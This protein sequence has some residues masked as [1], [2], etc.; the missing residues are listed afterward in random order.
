MGRMK[1]LSK[2][3][4]FA[5]K[6][7]TSEMEK[8]T[9]NFLHKRIF[10]TSS[11]ESVTFST[12]LLDNLNSRVPSLDSN[13]NLTKM[14]STESR[15]TIRIRGQESTEELVD[16]FARI[17]E[18]RE[19][20]DDS[21]TDLSR[22]GP[23]ASHSRMRTTFIE[24]SRD[25]ARPRL[26]QRRTTLKGLS[27]PGMDVTVERRKSKRVTLSGLS[28]TISQMSH[29]RNTSVYSRQSNIQ[30]NVAQ[31]RSTIVGKRKSAEKAQE[32]LA[33]RVG[34]ISRTTIGSRQ[35]TGSIAP[36][37][38][39]QSVTNL[40]TRAF[41]VKKAVSAFKLQR[42]ISNDR[43]KKKHAKDETVKET[44]VK[45]KQESKINIHGEK[46]PKTTRTGHHGMGRRDEN[47]PIGPI[48]ES[49]NVFKLSKNV[50]TEKSPSPE[51]T[52]QP[53]NKT[54]EKPSD[55]KGK[56]GSIKK[57]VSN[58]NV[59]TPEKKGELGKKESEVNLSSPTENKES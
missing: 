45:V 17:D 24:K 48:K 2:D 13:M 43:E 34:S 18:E 42:E 23:Q 25:L 20:D 9:D 51:Q 21:F 44:K 36:A 41:N 6:K 14:K 52:E 32:G 55:K 29:N 40:A 58:A 12:T 39:K 57:A 3:P 54:N 31:L 26:T 27:A 19:D 50:D 38:Q 7:F 11:V 47:G 4:D 35:N 59:K 56:W 10:N 53:A 5:D 15:C 49:V 46:K 1:D 33:E 22:Q 8:L 28:K 16:P 37:P 30:S